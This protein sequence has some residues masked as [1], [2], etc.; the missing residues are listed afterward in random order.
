MMLKAMASAA[1]DVGGACSTAGRRPPLGEVSSNRPPPR[2][3]SIPLCR[4]S[5]RSSVPGLASSDGRGHPSPLSTSEPKACSKLTALVEAH[6]LAIPASSASMSW[7]EHR[8]DSRYTRS[9]PSLTLATGTAVALSWAP[10]GGR[11]LAPTH[12]STTVTGP[13]SSY[14]AVLPSVCP[15]ARL[16]VRP[17]ARRPLS[18]L[19]RHVGVEQPRPGRADYFS[20]C[21]SSPLTSFGSLSLSLSRRRLAQQAFSD[22]DRHTASSR[23]TASRVRE[24]CRKGA[25][26]ASRACVRDL[27][28]TLPLWGSQV[29]LRSV[30]RLRP[31]RRLVVTALRWLDLAAA[32]RVR[33]KK[34]PGLALMADPAIVSS[35]IVLDQPPVRWRFRPRYHHDDLARITLLEAEPHALLVLGRP[36]RRRVG[37]PQRPFLRP[38]VGARARQAPDGRLRRHGRPGGPLWQLLPAGPARDSRAPEGRVPVEPLS[39]RAQPLAVHRPG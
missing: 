29:R 25:C 15:S 2:T 8:H 22:H 12:I 14:P 28:W 13:G 36:C 26:R 24:P 11:P 18:A 1:A 3:S 23:L 37:R 7:N 32:L 5:H 34:S 20:R 16:P 17:S 9:S 38:V 6:R 21:R 39:P 19:R 10:D 4:H 33:T 30:A 27:A 35:L 31:V